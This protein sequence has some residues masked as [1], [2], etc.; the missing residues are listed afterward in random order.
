MFKPGLHGFDPNSEM[1]RRLKEILSLINTFVKRANISLANILAKQE[2]PGG[3]V[4]YDSFVT[5]LR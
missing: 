1:G 2:T 4:L 5:A 3:L